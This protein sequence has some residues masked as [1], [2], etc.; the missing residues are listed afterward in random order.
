MKKTYWQGTG[1][2]QKLADKLHEIIESKLQDGRVE[3]P[4]LELYRRVQNCY[5]DLWNNGLI[6]TD[7]KIAF[8]LFGFNPYETNVVYRKDA[9]KKAIDNLFMRAEKITDRVILKA[10]KEQG[11]EIKGDENG[12][13]PI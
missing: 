3:Q 4:H 1:K 11:L 2:Y 8:E 5:Y 9:S 13:E 6:N 7:E 12:K 10:A